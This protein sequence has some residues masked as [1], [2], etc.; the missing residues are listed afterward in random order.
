MV[1]CRTVVQG[2]IG[3]QVTEVYES[4]NSDPNLRTCRKCSYVFPLTPMAE[5]VGFLEEKR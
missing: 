5:R 2:N 4:F 3:Q 1:L